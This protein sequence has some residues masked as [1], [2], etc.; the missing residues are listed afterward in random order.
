M[1]R[2]RSVYCR[3]WEEP[4]TFSKSEKV[5]HPGRVLVG[6]RLRHPPSIVLTYDHPLLVG[7]PESDR[8]QAKWRLFGNSCVT[9]LEIAA[10]QKE[11]TYRPVH[12]VGRVLTLVEML[13]TS[14]LL[15]LFA[16]AVQ[17]QF[18]R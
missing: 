15:G 5:G 2:K 10:F 7:Q 18:R 4:P 16:L 12:G 14:T 9:A 8:R 11:L 17:R 6:L 1:I 13:L 3:P